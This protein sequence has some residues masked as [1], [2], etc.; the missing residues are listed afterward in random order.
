MEI[1]LIV[2]GFAV[3]AYLLNRQR[4]EI[5]GLREGLSHTFEQLNVLKNLLEDGKTIRTTEE[6]DQV[7]L[8]TEDIPVKETDS[9]PEPILMEEEVTLTP[10]P[11]PDFL[12]QEAT[13]IQFQAEDQ[14]NT[15][16]DPFPFQPIVEEEK[17]SWFEKFK[18][19]NPDIEKFIGE[20]LINK[21]GIIIL[22]LGISFFVKYAIDK[23]WI[24]EPARVG[25]G[26]LAGGILL[27]VAHRM[28][29]QFKAF[30]SVL[31]AGAIAV[32]Y[33]TIGIAFHD[34]HLFSQ[35]TTF[36]IMVMITMFSTFVSMAYN[37]QELAVMSV[38][39]GF[40]VPFMV[41]TGHG[42]YHVLLTYITLLNVGMLTI[43]YFRRWFVVNF[44]AFILTTLIVAVWYIVLPS[45]TPTI[46]LHV[47]G[48]CT[49]LYILFMVAFVINNVVHKNKF[50]TYEIGAVISNTSAFYAIGYHIVH[51][52]NPNYV[53]LFTILLAGFN[54]IFAYLIFKKYRFDKTIVF[55]LIGL[56]L[57]LATITIPVQFE[58]N[59]VTIFWACEAVLL[60]WLTHKSQLKGFLLGAILVQWLAIISLVQDLA[61]YVEDEVA[62]TLVL[63]TVCI[64]GL[65]IIGSLVASY[66]LLQKHSY[67][68]TLSAIIFNQIAYRKFIFVCALVLAYILPIIEISYQAS[69]RFDNAGTVYFFIYLYHMI[70]STLLI[71]FGRYKTKSIETLSDVLIIA[72]AIFYIIVGYRIPIIEKYTTFIYNDGAFPFAFNLHYLS[73]TALLLQIWWYLKRDFFGSVELG[74]RNTYTAWLVAFFIVYL[75]SAEVNIVFLFQATDFDSYFTTREFVMKVI[76]PIL[77]GLLSFAFLIY[78]IKKSLKTARVI[79]LSLLG[80]TILKLFIYDIRDVSETGKI[81]AF[82]LLGALI[83]TISFVYQKIKKLVVDNNNEK[84]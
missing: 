82:I 36:I 69:F 76:F 79:A 33:F 15:I 16:Q 60:L 19:K 5:K 63:N 70:F 37:R 71:Y 35:T 73:L 68:Y 32:F 84:L 11:I 39:G 80:I 41:S 25:I 44:T 2:L 7:P 74:K 66:K 34:Y 77:W 1:L 62:H 18:Q 50:S 61:A 67:T 20:N 6:L 26:I 46:L 29:A 56:A 4:D 78:G 53:G 22:V 51:S 83:L 10:P 54:I 21:I 30:S 59:Y 3:L 45:S 8:I 48:Y 42:N 49:L 65:V 75:C 17:L 28:R 38:I 58:G 31:V 9:T 72:N 14:S 57:T 81:I 43:S 40:A 12:L 24:N 64:T 27:G 55:V 23:E 13:E 52:Y 47:F